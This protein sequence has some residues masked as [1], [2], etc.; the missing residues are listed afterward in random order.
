MKLIAAFLF[1]VLITSCATQPKQ[2]VS[3]QEPIVHV[4]TELPSTKGQLYLKTNQWLIK[5]FVKKNGI[6]ECRQGRGDING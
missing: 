5:T 2:K 3:F 4:F 6:I 1:A